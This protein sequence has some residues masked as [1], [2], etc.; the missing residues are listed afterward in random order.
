MEKLMVWSLSAGSWRIWRRISSC[1][2]R[3]P[4]RFTS[5]VSTSCPSYPSSFL[6][7]SDQF[8]QIWATLEF[9]MGPSS[10]AQVVR[11]S[12]YCISLLATV[13]ATI[14]QKKPEGKPEGKPEYTEK[15]L[16]TPPPPS[17]GI[18]RIDAEMIMREMSMNNPH[19]KLT[20]RVRQVDMTSSKTCASVVQVST[21]WQSYRTHGWKEQATANQSISPR[22]CPET[23]KCKSSN[24]WVGSSNETCTPTPSIYIYICISIN[25]ILSQHNH[26]L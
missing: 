6:I 24:Q 13:L 23:D 18:S 5:C 15:L 11:S 26:A 10:C 14:H 16:T 8:N 22:V 12:L 2:A 20:Q 9:R 4:S 17:A 1:S 3:L 19:T 25:L 7:S 21:Y